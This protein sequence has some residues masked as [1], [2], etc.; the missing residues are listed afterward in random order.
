M[1][2]SAIRV[3]VLLRGSLSQVQSFDALGK[4][5]DTVRDPALADHKGYGRL[6]FGLYVQAI[7]IMLTSGLSCLVSKTC[8]SLSSLT[9][10]HVSSIGAV[11]VLS[12]HVSTM[13]H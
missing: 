10:P 8:F 13:F 4:E 12:G 9:W 1:D 3:S 6:F 2:A 11:T 7:S 5:R